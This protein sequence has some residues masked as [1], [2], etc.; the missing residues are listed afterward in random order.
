MSRTSMADRP[1][2]ARTAGKQTAEAARDDD[3]QV[4]FALVERA[5]HGDAEAFAEV[6]QR[7]VDLIYRY[8]LARVAQPALAEDL[9]SETFLRALTRINTVTFQGRDLGAWLVT[10]AR[11]LL[12]DHFKSG[13]ARLEIAFADPRAAEAG[14]PSSEAAALGAMSLRQ[15][16]AAVAALGPEQRECVV[17]RFLHGQ[18]V[19]ETAGLMGRN[20]GSVKALQHRAVRSL[21]RSL[22]AG[23]S[24][25]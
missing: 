14:T 16:L 8:L 2:T 18:S 15:L 19:A 1:R 25:G 13:R 7:Y 22:P 5:Q 11:N 23:A 17:L 3:V 9:T 20:P 12:A 6:Y 21:A 10:I 24:L 4:G